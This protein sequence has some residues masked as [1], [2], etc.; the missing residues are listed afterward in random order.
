MRC[1]LLSA[2]LENGMNAYHYLFDRILK[3]YNAKQNRKDRV[4]HNYFGHMMESK[5]EE[6]FYE[7]VVQF[8]DSVTSPC[9]SERGDQARQLLE[10]YMRDFQRRNPNLYDF[11]AVLHMDAA[12]PH[13]HSRRAMLLLCRA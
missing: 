1:C 13:L 6:A 4:I 10:C 8:G 12:S 11:N 3:E 9:G 7:I 5:R 2:L